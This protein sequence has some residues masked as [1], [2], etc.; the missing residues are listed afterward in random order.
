MNREK[1]LININLGDKFG[2]YLTYI[3]LG[4]ACLA[5]LNKCAIQEYVE[6][7]DRQS[8]GVYRQEA[9]YTTY[10]VEHVKADV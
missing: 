4:L 8:R 9:Q 10:N 6:T 7:L 5:F 1:H 2:L 3:V